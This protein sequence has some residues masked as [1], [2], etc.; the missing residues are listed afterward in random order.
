MAQ[1]ILTY[2]D[3]V[4]QRVV[5]ALCGRFGYQAT[6]QNGLPNPQTRA[7]FAKLQIANFIKDTVAGWEATIAKE[8]AEQTARETANREIAVA[9]G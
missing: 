3:A 7:Q 1:V 5:D 9:F 8:S 2:P 4:A 6:L